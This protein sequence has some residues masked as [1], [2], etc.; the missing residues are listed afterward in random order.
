MF[1]KTLNRHLEVMNNMGGLSAQIE[2]TLD[3]ILACFKRDGKLLL[4]GNGGSAS[5]AQHLAAEF[6]VRY[7]E[8]RPALPA[9]AL[10]TDTSIITAH[11]NDFG[12][13]TLFSRQV[14]ALGKSGDVLIGISTS[15]NSA[16]VVAALE[17]AKAQGIHT[18]ALTGET[19]GKLKLV[20]DL[21]LCVPSDETAR[22]QE[23]HILIGHYW[24]EQVD[25]HYANT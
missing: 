15:G 4:C 11:T 9:I 8:N 23:A 3:T 19:G 24:C 7:Y 22:V 12:F 14:E 17:A 10:T 20:A 21:C 18:I 16:N 6:V 1:T 25:K 13:E 5:D 2:S